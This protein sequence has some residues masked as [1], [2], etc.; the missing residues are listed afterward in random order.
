MD[1]LAAIEHAAPRFFYL[2]HGEET[3]LVE[4]A[5]AVLRA[6]LE[7]AD[8]PGGWRVLWSD[9]AGDRLRAALDDLRSPLLFGGAAVVVVRR[10]EAFAAADEEWLM[11]A[12]P[13]LG[14]SGRLVLVG[15]AVDMRRKLPAFCVRQGAAF[16]FPRVTEAA[17]ARKWIV[18]IAGELGHQIRPAATDALLARS[19]ADLGQLANEVAKVALHAGDGAAI[20][21]SDVEAA[22]TV[23]RTHAVEELTDCLAHGDRAGASLALR[24]LLARGEPPIKLAAFLV[25]SLRR[26]LHVAELTEQGLGIEEAAARL[27]APA[28]LVRKNRGR[29]RA[30]DL[31]RALSAFADLDLALKS[32]RPAAATF[33]AVLLEVCAATAGSRS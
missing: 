10:V 5:L 15:G 2:L 29:G 7:G 18:R 11:S 4:R 6:R 21:V 20:D 33:E 14:A 32:S 27:G 16:A 31:E 28:W 30:R 1:A 8:R 13:E 26:A 25:S 3:F 12:L 17:V 23:T 19:A 9:D 22:M 24:D